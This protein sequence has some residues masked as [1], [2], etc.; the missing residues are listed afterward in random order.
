M[1]SAAIAAAE[2]LGGFITAESGTGFKCVNRA[3]ARY[4]AK[5]YRRGKTV[6]LGGADSPEEAALLYLM[7]PEGDR[8]R[9]QRGWLNVTV[10]ASTSLQYEVGATHVSSFTPDTLTSGSLDHSANTT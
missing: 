4:Y 3:G 9:Q 6:V 1:T 2:L 7:S 10:S 5:V 8:E